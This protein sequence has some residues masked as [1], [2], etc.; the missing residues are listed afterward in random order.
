[1]L[2]ALFAVKQRFYQVHMLRLLFARSYWQVNQPIKIE[3][4][5]KVNDKYK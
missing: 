1:M 5:H 2:R 3:H 4:T